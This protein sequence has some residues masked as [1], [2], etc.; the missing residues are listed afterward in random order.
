MSETNLASSY[1][2]LSIHI[3]AIHPI[4]G[5]RF[6]PTARSYCVVKQINVGRVKRG[7]EI[8]FTQQHKGLGA[9]C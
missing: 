6:L 5:S 8:L 9:R 7:Y 4:R 3:R 2:I 1:P